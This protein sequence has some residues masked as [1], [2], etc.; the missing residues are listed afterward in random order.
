M[1]SNLFRVLAISIFVPTPSVHVTIFGFLNFFGISVIE[2][3][4]PIFDNFFCPFFVFNFEIN[5]IKL[6]AAEIFTPLFFYRLNFLQSFLKIMNLKV[7]HSYKCFFFFII[8]FP[9]FYIFLSTTNVYSKK[10]R[11]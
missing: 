9:L 5:F 2:P 8:L 4:P 10:F 6:S 11:N 7:I 3:K 1:V